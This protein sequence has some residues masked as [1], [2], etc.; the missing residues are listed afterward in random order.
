MI[1]ELTKI[2]SRYEPIPVY[3]TAVVRVKGT[4]GNWYESLWS[5][6]LKRLEKIIDRLKRK[7]RDIMFNYSYG[8]G[9]HIDD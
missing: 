3:V 4:D 2:T 6:S 9:L 5:G 8:M 7:G 1:M